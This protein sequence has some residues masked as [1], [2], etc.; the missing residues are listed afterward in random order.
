MK[1]RSFTL[2][3]NA[4]GNFFLPKYILDVLSGRG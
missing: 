2:R 1:A 3:E 4:G